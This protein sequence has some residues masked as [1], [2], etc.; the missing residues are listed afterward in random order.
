MYVSK[1]TNSQIA[2]IATE[3]LKKREGAKDY[4][5]KK[6]EKN[7]DSVIIDVV[8]TFKEEIK[9]LYFVMFDCCMMYKINGDR[10]EPNEYYRGKMQEWFGNDY[11]EKINNQNR[12]ELA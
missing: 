3:I 9:E 6:L 1:L 4:I 10:I 5:I 2:E 7:Q 11:I 12:K 8:A